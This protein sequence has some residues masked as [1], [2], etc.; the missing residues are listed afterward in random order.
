MN[1][2]I[3]TDASTKRPDRVMTIGNKAVVVDYKF[4]KPSESNRTQIAQYVELLE[5]MG[6]KDVEGYVWYIREQMID[7]VS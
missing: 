4:G 1:A 3:M 5:S 2:I 7:R 6:Y